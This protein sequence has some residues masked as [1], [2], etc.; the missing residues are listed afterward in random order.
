MKRFGWLL[1][2]DNGLEQTAFRTNEADLVLM[3][4]NWHQELF[5]NGNEIAKAVNKV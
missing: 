3:F 5:R 2:P 1:S 4:K